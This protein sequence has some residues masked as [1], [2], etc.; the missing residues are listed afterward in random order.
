MLRIRQNTAVWPLRLL[1]SAV[2]ALLT[3]PA[4]AALQVVT[5][6]T[7]LAYFAA[8]IGGDR[9]TTEALARPQEDLHAVQ[10]KPSFLARINKADLFVQVGLD[11]ETW[12]PPLLAKTSRA[13]LRPGGDGYVLA[14]ANTTLLEVPCCEVDRSMGDIHAQGNPHCWLESGN[15]KVMAADIR[16]GLVRID[17]TGR[18]TYDANYQALAQRIDQAS[19]EAKRILQPY[20]GALVVQHHSSFVYLFQMLGVTAAASLEPRPGIA[21]GAGHLAALKTQMAKEQIRVITTEASL[22]QKSSRSLATSTG[23]S[24]VTLGQ[25][26]G[27]L[28]DTPSWEALILAN[29]RRLAEGLKGDAR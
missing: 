19:A 6:T 8:T 18:A 5:T 13:S 29:A 7:D 22:N 25:H 12:V 1:L 15:A 17:P 27:S 28:P 14:S 24:L 2:L 26:V 16:D 21:P 4:Y 20:A 3:S 9:V 11:L 10:V 23:A